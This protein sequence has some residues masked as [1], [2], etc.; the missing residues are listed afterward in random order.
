M[1][2]IQGDHITA[3][4]LRAWPAMTVDGATALVFETRELGTIAIRVPIGATPLFRQLIS[5]IEEVQQLGSG[6]A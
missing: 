1:E 2:R 4:V 6:K 3:T 5:R